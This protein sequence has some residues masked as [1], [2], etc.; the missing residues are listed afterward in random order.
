MRQEVFFEVDMGVK[1]FVEKG[2]EWRRSGR[3]RG[4]GSRERPHCLHV[5]DLHVTQGARAHTVGRQYKRRVEDVVFPSRQ[6]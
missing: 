1:R 3:G 4:R 2:Q 5:E 6:Q